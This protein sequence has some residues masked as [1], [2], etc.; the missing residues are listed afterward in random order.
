MYG[1][2]GVAV[3][4][5]VGMPAIDQERPLIGWCDLR[6]VIRKSFPLQM[7]HKRAKRSIREGE[8]A[9]RYSRHSV[10][11]LALTRLRKF[12][13]QGCRTKHLHRLRG[14]SATR[15]SQNP[16]LA[17]WML[18]ESALNGS[19]RLGNGSGGANSRMPWPRPSPNP[20]RSSRRGDRML[21][22]HRRTR[23]SLR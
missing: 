14:T 18:P 3:T 2:T 19:N 20:E 21:A 16:L 10:S 8:R 1:M 13:I 15:R 11:S 5:T 23:S 6:Y 7:P 4:Q 9:E 22:L 12:A 17:S